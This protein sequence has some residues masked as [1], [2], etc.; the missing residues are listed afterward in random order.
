[1]IPVEEVTATN[2]VELGDKIYSMMLEDLG[3][4]YAPENTETT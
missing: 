2:T 4:E 1:V 3:P